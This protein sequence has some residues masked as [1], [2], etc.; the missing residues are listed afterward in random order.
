MSAEKKKETLS[1]KIKKFAQD[2][3]KLSIK[4]KTQYIAIVLIIAVILAIY[5]SSIADKTKQPN[6]PIA[7]Q[8]ASTQSEDTEEKLKATLSKINGAGKVEVMITYK[9]GP[10]IVPAFSIDTQKEQHDGYG[11]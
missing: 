1:E 5:F 6:A 8:P 9:S 11:G 10:E 2:Y 3:K 7:T 4:K